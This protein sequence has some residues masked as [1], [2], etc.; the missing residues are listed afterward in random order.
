MCW[1]PTSVDCLEST[2][3]RP[4]TDRRLRSKPANRQ[5]NRKGSPETER[6]GGERP[7]L[8]SV[9]AATVRRHQHPQQRRRTRPGR[10]TD[11][12]GSGAGQEYL[13][14]G[15][16]INSAQNKRGHDFCTRLKQPRMDTVMVWG[17]GIKCLIFNA[18]ISLSS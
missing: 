9:P 16:S 10:G 13:V 18:A 11:L 14:T 12:G 3:A 5:R 1:R 4:Y 8:Q 7:V 15:H 2:S 17:L 6:N